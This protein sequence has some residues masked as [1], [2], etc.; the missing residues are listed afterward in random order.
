MLSGGCK[1]ATACIDR[2]P[3][4]RPVGKTFHQAVTAEAL[5]RGD[6]TLI[7]GSHG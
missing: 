3:A 1:A 6:V 7:T 5:P 2:G 4:F